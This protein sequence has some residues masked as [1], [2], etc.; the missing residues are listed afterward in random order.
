ML[1]KSQ[2]RFCKNTM[3]VIPDYRIIQKHI[4]NSETETKYVSGSTNNLIGSELRVTSGYRFETDFSS[5][6]I[7][8]CL[9][10]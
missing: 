2:N 7:E 4:N 9:D 5:F 1:P 3:N 6:G 10:L 8:L